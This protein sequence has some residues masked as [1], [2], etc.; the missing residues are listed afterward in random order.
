MAGGTAALRESSPA[1]L[2]R[3]EDETV[4]EFPLRGREALVVEFLRVA[5]MFLRADHPRMLVGVVEHR[6]A[7]LGAGVGRGRVPE[8]V[9]EKDRGAGRR[10]DLHGAGEEIAALPVLLG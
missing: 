2:G 5:P 1:L 8:G 7:A 4:E 6:A 9:V 3:V 10:A